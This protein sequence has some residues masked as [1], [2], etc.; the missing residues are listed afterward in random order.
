[1]SKNGPFCPLKENPKHLQQQMVF[2]I[3]TCYPLSGRVPNVSNNPFPIR[4]LDN[5]SRKGNTISWSV[6]CLRPHQS[7]SLTTLL[8]MIFKRTFQSADF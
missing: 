6:N 7:I 5:N 1:M 8:E 3:I 2:F 4:F